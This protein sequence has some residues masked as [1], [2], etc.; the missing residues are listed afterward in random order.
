MSDESGARTCPAC[1]SGNTRQYGT[2]HVDDRQTL[3]L[4]QCNE[5]RCAHRWHTVEEAARQ[6]WLRSSVLLE[7]P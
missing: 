4:R 1:G 3:R 6:V 7:E 2:R 5:T